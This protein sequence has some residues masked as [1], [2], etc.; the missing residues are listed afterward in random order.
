MDNN[1]DLPRMYLEASIN[2]EEATEA[3][4]EMASACIDLPTGKNKQADLLYF[5][6]VFVSSGANLNHAYFLP[7]ELVAAEGTIQTKAVDMEHIEDQVVGHIYD[8]VYVDSEHNPLQLQELS[9]LE[10]AALNEKELHIVIAG[11]VYKHRF[12]ELCEEVSKNE[13]KVSMECFYQNY[14]VKIGNTIMSKPEAELLGL[15]CEE[16]VFGKVAK[17][18]K[19]GK[20]IADGIID[21]VLRG[22]H[23]AGVGFVKQPANPPSVVLETAKDTDTKVIDE[24][25]CIIM[26]DENITSAQD[27][28]NVTS[29]EVEGTINNSD[30]KNNIINDTID[31]E[32]EI[33]DTEE[34]EIVYKDTVGICVNYKKQVT[35]KNGSIIHENWCTAYKQECTSFSRDT[36]DPDCLRNQIKATAKA[37]ISNIMSC[38]YSEKSKE[39]LLNELKAALHEAV[40]TLS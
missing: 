38:N 32:E 10:T 3:R 36:T 28:N 13:W 6:A 14:D 9:K 40:K 30:T 17:V 22:V 25:N 39:M 34:S 8:K 23:F 5:S 33:T 16:N 2:I 15:A 29:E 12:P 4:K 26:V 31:L 11:V 35:D 20:E 21:R 19:N 18:I 7:S 1:K 24:D 37:V 27:N